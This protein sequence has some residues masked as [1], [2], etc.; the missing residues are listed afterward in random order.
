MKRNIAKR[1]QRSKEAT[2]TTGFAPSPVSGI[3][4]LL[5]P[6][7]VLVLPIRTRTACFFFPVI[8]QATSHKPSILSFRLSLSRDTR[9]EETMSCSIERVVDGHVIVLR[10]TI[11]TRWP[12]CSSRLFPSRCHVPSSV[13]AMRLVTYQ[14]AQH[15]VRP[16]WRTRRR[17]S[18]L[19]QQEKERRAVIDSPLPFPVA[20]LFPQPWPGSLTCPLLGERA[21]FVFAP[22]RDAPRDAWAPSLPCEPGCPRHGRAARRSRGKEDQGWALNIYPICLRASSFPVRRR[23]RTVCVSPP[24]Y[25]CSTCKYTYKTGCTAGLC[26]NTDGRGRHRTGEI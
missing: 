2:K 25:I 21:S 26:A 5:S 20:F 4:C 12:F 22:P 14:A 9:R 11:N 17:L 8:M 24:T 13:C 15:G 10:G 7:C 16:G 23:G 6:T 3:I 19:A 18:E 1:K